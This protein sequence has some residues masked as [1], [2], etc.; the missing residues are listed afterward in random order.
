MFL[1]EER[2]RQRVGFVFLL[3]LM[4][5]RYDFSYIGNLTLSISANLYECLQ[6]IKE[7]SAPLKRVDRCCQIK[8]AVDGVKFART[9]A[10]I[11]PSFS[12]LFF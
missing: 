3:C 5:S 1:E 12:C 11:N 7:L 8:G 2:K 10:L 4:F 6:Y 9:S